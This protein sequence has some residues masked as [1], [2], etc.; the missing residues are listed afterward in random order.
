MTAL[1]DT[2][3]GMSEETAAHAFEPFYTTKPEGRGT[4]LG[5]S[6]V[7]G[8]VKQSGG[9]IKLYSEAGCGTTVKIYLPRS[10]A[11]GDEQP[12]FSQPKA[13]A[14]SQGESVLVVEDDPGVRTYSAE[15]LATLGY[16]VL[17][18]SDGHAALRLLENNRNI[19]L[20][21]TD[22]GLPGLNGRLLAEEAQRRVP[23]LKVLYTTA[24][25]RNAIVHHGILD[26]GVDLLPKP[27]TIEALGRKL[28]QIVGDS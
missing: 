6:Q 26:A 19:A 7:Y 2:G 18:A 3:N 8:F 4:G 12:A 24:Y 21:F 9:H 11:T 23:G 27:F 25:A 15:A 5:L 17:Q 10:A 28:Q 20:L 14:A 13:V 22:V 1:T 16:D